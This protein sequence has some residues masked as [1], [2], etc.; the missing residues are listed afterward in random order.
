MQERKNQLD[1]H[2]DNHQ[3]G[4]VEQSQNICKE[5]HYLKVIRWARIYEFQELRKNWNM[6]VY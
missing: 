4:Y 2:I 1:G 3:Q 6:N 5:K